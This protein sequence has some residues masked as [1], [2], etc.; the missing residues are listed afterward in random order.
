MPIVGERPRP[1]ALFRGFKKEEVESFEKFFPT[2]RAIHVPSEVRQQ[3]WDVLVVKDGGGVFVDPGVYVLSFGA[4]C[5]DGLKCDDVPVEDDDR[6]FN[7]EVGGV[8]RLAYRVSGSYG[9]RPGSL[10]TE[11]LIPDDLDPDVARL[12]VGDIVPRLRGE[13]SHYCL[14]VGTARCAWSCV[15]LCDAY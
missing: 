2:R 15:G 6:A 11:F 14:G 5:V 12:V 10:A 7:V 8:A 13:E 4:F 9:E 3:E 1:R